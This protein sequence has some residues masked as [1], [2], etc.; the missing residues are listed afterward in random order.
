MLRSHT[1]VNKGHPTPMN[2]GL[3]HWQLMQPMAP[4]SGVILTSPTCRR[5]HQA[6]SHPEAS[7]LFGAALIHIAPK[8]IVL[9]IPGPAR[10]SSVTTVSRTVA[11]RKLHRS[12]KPVAVQIS[13]VAWPAC[14]NAT[15]VCVVAIEMRCGICRSTISIQ[16]RRHELD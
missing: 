14:N 11:P 2:A 6:P 1:P 13:P 5:N 3:S 15:Q 8:M 10:L 7:P 4:C 9:G 16:S 12:G